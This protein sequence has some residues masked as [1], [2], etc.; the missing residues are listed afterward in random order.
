[1]A[2]SPLVARP[3]THSRKTRGAVRAFDALRE[4]IPGASTNVSH[5]VSVEVGELQAAVDLDVVVDCG[6]GIVEVTIAVGDV[7][8]PGD[9]ATDGTQTPVIS[10]RVA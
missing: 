10:T 5:G 7:H 3:H 9:D 8:L 4:R 2:A 6:V 1:M